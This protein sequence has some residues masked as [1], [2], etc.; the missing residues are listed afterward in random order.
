V[1]PRPPRRLS[2]QERLNPNGTC[3][4]CGQANPEGLGLRSY[5]EGDE[6]VARVAVPAKMEN[7]YGIVNGGIVTMVL[8]CH[9]A[10]VVV[11][12]L[13]GSDWEHQPPFLTS[14]LEVSL[15]RPTPIETSLTVVGRLVERR[16]TELLVAAEIR[17]PDG[18]VTA[19][20]TAGW[21]PVLRKL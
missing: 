18:E 20:L 15:R 12:T 3:Y 8:D 6:V 2:I 21:R 4:G 13:K 16:S 14:H 1:E 9:T 17:R 7:G 5:V 10:A 19:Q 11:E